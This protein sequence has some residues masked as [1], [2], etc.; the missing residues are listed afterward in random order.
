M[1]PK[2]K[3]HPNPE[4][5]A[6]RKEQ[7]LCAAAECFRR[8]GYH[9]ASMAEISKTAGMSPGHIYNY[10]D[11]K[12]AIINAIISQQMADM[13]EVFA[14]LK[15][16]PGELHE[17]MLAGAEHGVCNKLEGPMAS[18]K[19]EMLAETCRNE[20]IAEMLRHADTQARA[21]F[22]SILQSERS[23]IRDLPEAE[24]QARISVIFAMF[25]G[26]YIRQ[27]L[28]PGLCPQLVLTALRP[29]LRTLLSP[30]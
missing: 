8:R 18:L 12:D 7:V 9:G 15:A 11:S 25:D 21:S 30:F 14:T 13:F 26:L 22:M 1:E 2:T 20:G 24:L 3:R 29:A 16:Q 10:F 23:P 5:A 4:R 6:A 27:T 19:L 28:Q 17:V